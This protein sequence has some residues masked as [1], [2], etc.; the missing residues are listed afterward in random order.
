MAEIEERLVPVLQK[1]RWTISAERIHMGGNYQEEST[2]GP[3]CNEDDS[4]LQRNTE[5]K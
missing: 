2:P 1:E 3:V 4:G 5:R